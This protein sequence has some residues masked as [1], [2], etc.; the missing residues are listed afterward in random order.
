MIIEMVEHLHSVA[1]NFTIKVENNFDLWE[2][3][4][5]LEVIVTLNDNPQDYNH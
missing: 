3:N 1:V 5:L 2:C 4:Y